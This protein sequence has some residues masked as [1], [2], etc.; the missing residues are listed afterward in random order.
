MTRITYQET[1]KIDFKGFIKSI[2]WYEILL[3]YIVLELFFWQ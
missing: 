2:K 1:S 3:A